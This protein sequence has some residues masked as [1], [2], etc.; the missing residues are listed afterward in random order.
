MTEECVFGGDIVQELLLLFNE[1]IIKA[2]QVM[3]VVL[4]SW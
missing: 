2:R 4:F 1:R 3:P